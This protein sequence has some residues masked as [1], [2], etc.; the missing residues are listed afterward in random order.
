MLIQQGNSEVLCLA[1]LET[2]KGVSVK[3]SWYLLS[4]SFPSREVNAQLSWQVEC[5]E[6]LIH[7]TSNNVK[8][9]GAGEVRDQR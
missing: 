3:Y 5:G 6:M 1:L 8:G 4:R 2:R 9:M 7:S